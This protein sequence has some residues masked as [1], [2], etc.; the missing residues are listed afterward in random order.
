LAEIA[1][2]GLLGVVQEAPWTLGDDVAASVGMSLPPWPYAC[3]DAPA[4]GWTLARGAERH[5]WPEGLRR[6]GEAW[7]ACD[8]WLGYVSARGRA[9]AGAGLYREAAG[10]A[11]RTVREMAASVPSLQCRDDVG[12]PPRAGRTGDARETSASAT[13]PA[14]AACDAPPPYDR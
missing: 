8:A 13:P 14:A 2:G 9:G 6:E 11:Y 5:L 7:L 1:Y 4:A 12:I 3:E 10:R